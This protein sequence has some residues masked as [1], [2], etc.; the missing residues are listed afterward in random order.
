[1]FHSLLFNQFLKYIFDNYRRILIPLKKPIDMFQLV[2]IIVMRLVNKRYEVVSS[3]VNCN[4]D[5][6]LAIT[7][8]CRDLLY[9]LTLKM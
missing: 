7:Y 4:Y 2:Q 8:R 1:M 3:K 5:L 6:S 9:Y